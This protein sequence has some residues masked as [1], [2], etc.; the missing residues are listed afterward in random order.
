[1]AP[2]IPTSTCSSE[3]RYHEDSDE[4]SPV[5]SPRVCQCENQLAHFDWAGRPHPDLPECCRPAVG[6]ATMASHI[7]VD[8][9]K[10]SVQ[11]YINSYTHTVL[12]Q[13]TMEV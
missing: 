1:M 6:Y 8:D 9:G 11:Q 7:A 13:K 2:A 3:D 4:D 12:Q 5:S 10:I